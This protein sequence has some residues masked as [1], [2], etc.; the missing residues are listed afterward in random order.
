[1][2]GLTWAEECRWPSKNSVSEP[3]SSAAYVK[4]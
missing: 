1:M 2:R 3:L 4:D